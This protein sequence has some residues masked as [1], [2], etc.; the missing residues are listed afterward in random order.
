MRWHSPPMNSGSVA[1]SI[2]STFACAGQTTKLAPPGTRGV[3][4]RKKNSVKAPQTAPR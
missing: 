4:S 1:V 2:T 3:G